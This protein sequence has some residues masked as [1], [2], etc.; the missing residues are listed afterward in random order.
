MRVQRLQLASINGQTRDGV[1]LCL[2]VFA[3]GG[4]MIL[5]IALNYI[6][7]QVQGA[8]PHGFSFAFSCSKQTNKHTP[9]ITLYMNIYLYQ[10]IT[11]RKVDNQS[12][13]FVFHSCLFSCMWCEKQVHLFKVRISFLKFVENVCLH[14]LLITKSVSVLFTGLSE[15]SKILANGQL[16]YLYHWD[17]FSSFHFH[18]IICGMHDLYSQIFSDIW[19]IIHQ[20]VL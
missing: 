13:F 15:S 7:K 16:P 2:C 17:G 20:F 3:F 19:Q 12:F 4:G 11:N 10:Y 1:C 5:L 8:G 14:W 9:S 6:H 18:Y